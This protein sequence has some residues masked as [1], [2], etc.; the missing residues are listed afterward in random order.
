MPLVSVGLG[1]AAAAL[2]FWGLALLLIPPSDYDPDLSALPA[3]VV[4]ALSI[5]G[6]LIGALFRQRSGAR[7]PLLHLV[8][9]LIAVALICLLPL[10]IPLALVP[11]AGIMAGAYGSSGVIRL[12]KTVQPVD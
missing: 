12:R 6:L 1:A 8:G 4:A 10:N 3:I 7:L 9:A 11:Y 5:G 2:V